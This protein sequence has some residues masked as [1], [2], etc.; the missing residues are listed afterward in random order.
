[1]D[2][3]QLKH[4]RGRLVAILATIA[5]FVS[6]VLIVSTLAQR[7]SAAV[8]TPDM[9]TMSITLPA[10]VDQVDLDSSKDIVRTGTTISVEDPTGANSLAGVATSE[11]KGNRCWAWLPPRPGSCWPTTPTPH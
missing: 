8:Y 1:M 6:L 4:Q 7:A 5:L 3:A 9:P 10:G 2:F 11:I